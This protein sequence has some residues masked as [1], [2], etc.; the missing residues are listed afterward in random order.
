M[1]ILHLQSSVRFSHIVASLQQ[2]PDH[3][4]AVTEPE[5]FA[6]QVFWSFVRKVSKFQNTTD[7]KLSVIK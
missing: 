2:C 5:T 4:A 7:Y 6:L 3:V 1:N